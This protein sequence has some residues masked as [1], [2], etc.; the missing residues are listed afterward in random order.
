MRKNLD[1][2]DHSIGDCFI[3][4]KGSV[5]VTKETIFYYMF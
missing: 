4:F 5:L 3:I 2:F 1:E